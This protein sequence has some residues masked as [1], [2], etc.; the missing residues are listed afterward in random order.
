MG[1]RNHRFAER[2]QLSVGFAESGHG[3]RRFQW[4][5][6]GTHSQ[7][8]Q[9]VCAART[10]SL[11]HRQLVRRRHAD[12]RFGLRFRDILLGRRTLHRNHR[13]WSD[14]V[15]PIRRSLLRAC[16]SIWSECSKH[17]LRTASMHISA[18]PCFSRI[19]GE[20]GPGGCLYARP[21]IQNARSCSNRSHTGRAPWMRR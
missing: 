6:P 2:G 16:G 19:F 9:G 13:G 20:A 10:D 3:H 18:R 12:G 11:L 1:S 14:R 21:L 7:T 8:V 4:L 17:V 5:G 15:R